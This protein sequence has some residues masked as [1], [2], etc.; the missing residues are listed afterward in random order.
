[1][2][3]GAGAGIESFREMGGGFLSREIKHKDDGVGGLGGV[4]QS[5]SSRLSARIQGWF[6]SPSAEQTVA[7]TQSRI[8]VKE[9]F[10]GLLA[11][12][13]GGKAAERALSACRL[14]SDFA[15][16]D[17]PLT[18][19][20][21]K[22]ILD[23]AQE[24]RLQVTTSNENLL[25]RE[26]KG[27]EGPENRDLRAAIS[28]EVKNNAE[29]GSKA[30][31]ADLIG[32]M[33][34]KAEI[35]HSVTRQKQCEEQFPNVSKLIAQA[36]S[37]SRFESVERDA[38][39]LTQGLR[40]VVFGM[41]DSSKTGAPLGHAL[42]LL[43]TAAGLLGRQAWNQTS[44][45]ALSKELAN[46]REDIEAASHE[47][48]RISSDVLESSNKLAGDD[49]Q[50]KAGETFRLC[51]ALQNDLNHQIGKLEAKSTYVDEMRLTDPLTDRSI[52]H[53]NLLAGYA[54][55]A[56]LD[57]LQ[58]DAKLTGEQK[59]GLAI[60]SDRWSDKLLALKGEYD[61]SSNLDVLQP[62]AAGS[63]ANKAN[64]PIV[65]GKREV[66]L[67][68]RSMLEEAGISEKTL[69]SLFSK[70][71]TGR[72]DRLAL[73]RIDTWQPVSRDMVVMRDGVM[74]VYKSEIT[75][76]QHVHASLGV[77]DGKGGVG[78]VSAGVK[79]SQDHARNLK[80]SRLVDPQGQV[81]STVI[82]HGVLDMWEV[83]GDQARSRAN[84]QGAKEVL[85]LALSSNDRLRAGL[86]A[87]GAGAAPPRLVH[88]SVN[89]ISPDTAREWIP[90][91]SARDYKERTY[92]FNQFKAFDAN[93]GPGQTLR[94]FDPTNPKAEPGTAKVDV[95]TIT[96][97]F[98]I[99]AIA[100]GWK[101]NL[102]DVWSNVHAHNTSNMIKLVG[103]LGDGSFGSRG[104]RPG[105]S[106]GEVYDR[107]EVMR[108]DD[109]AN[110]A[111]RARAADVMAQ[112]R[113]QTDLVRS[114][115]TEETFKQGNGDTAKMGREVLVLQGLAE[116]GL[117]TLKATDLA[118]TSS[119]GCKS[120]KDRGGVTDVDLKSKLILRD[121][122]GE[123]VPDERLVGDDQGVYYTVS[124]SSGQLENQRW[125]TGM[126]GSKEAGHL[127]DRLPDPEVRQFL[128]GLGAFAKA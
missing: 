21:V 5:S 98:G 64:H 45:V 105:G 112:L 87:Q 90:T 83:K 94:V 69:K 73:S 79:D 23:S 33:R 60:V 111:D 61:R 8:Q 27:L 66:S 37:G 91:E 78:G 35:D 13:E 24:Y 115:F 46:C 44:L 106:V 40:G 59:L 92:T 7:K 14:P 118:G 75:P 103:D 122:G 126:A 3:I 123:L 25:G 63:K 56:L 93:S 36:P 113:G 102:M 108:E 86:L 19:R 4:R 15:Q 31:S 88:V 54:C 9:Q 43:D 58:T 120:D 96:F 29:F 107:L 67:S 76:A 116:Q 70:D 84:N 53:S 77:T 51:K 110:P 32:M 42:K 11:K 10:F 2:I 48:E 85:E 49:L 128:S 17:R 41:H 6:S 1:M 12:T 89:L 72:A 95:D 74:R 71:S 57:D 65:S 28:R 82:G 68:L 30:F 50:A 34:E 20:I 22:Q 39:K 125:N 97:S 16:N 109:A 124:A 117:E 101:Q 80:V 99:N 47:L 104:T 38:T 26:L 121:L 18:N 114:M 55:T 100:T 81:M 52:K 119:K 62:I 127:K